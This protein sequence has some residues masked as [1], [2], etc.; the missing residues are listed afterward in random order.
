MD[1]PLQRKL[2]IAGFDEDVISEHIDRPGLRDYIIL[3]CT[4][5]IEAVELCL[6]DAELRILVIDINTG[7]LNGFEVTAHLRKVLGKD[8]VIIMLGWFTQAA[9]ELAYSVGCDE[10]IS[11]PLDLEVIASLLNKKLYGS[12]RLPAERDK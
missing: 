9:A 4:S 10:F 6:A 5:G 12:L 8:I 1:S 3:R 11:K 2:L 7:H